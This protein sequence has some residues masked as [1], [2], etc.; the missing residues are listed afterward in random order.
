M[1]VAY[2]ESTWK[3]EQDVYMTGFIWMHGY[4]VIDNSKWWHY[5]NYACTKNREKLWD[6]KK[7]RAGLQQPAAAQEDFTQVVCAQRKEKQAK[8]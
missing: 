2:Y 1:K 5:C 8:K 4:L 6:E 3:S 7:T